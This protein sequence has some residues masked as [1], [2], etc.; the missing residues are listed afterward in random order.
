MKM[1]RKEY[2]DRLNKMYDDF[3]RSGCNYRNCSFDMCESQNNIK[4]DYA[5]KIGEDYGKTGAYKVLIVGKESTCGHQTTKKP[6]DDISKSP[7]THYRGTLYTLALLLTD[8]IPQSTSVNDL[9]KYNDL[10]KQFCLTNYFKCAF[11]K[12]NK[13][14]GLP[15]NKTMKD[16]CHQILLQEIDIL[17]PN[18]VVMQGKF[19]NKSFW[20]ILEKDE[21]E[22]KYGENEP[23]SLYRYTLNGHSFYVLWSYHPAGPQWRKHIKQLIEAVSVFKNCQL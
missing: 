18:I 7:N 10:L 5:T 9:I 19:T 23:I 4:F 13:V 21:Y 8:E 15:I 1:T 3:Y 20:N 12:D 17:K 6:S 16:S 14:R 11:R 22:C 2:S